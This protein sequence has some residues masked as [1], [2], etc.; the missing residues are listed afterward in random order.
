MQIKYLNRLSIHKL[1]GKTALLRVDLNIKAG[2]I[3]DVYRLSAIIPTLA[4]LK[5]AKVKTI[6]LSHRGRPNG[7]D[8]SLSLKNFAPLLAKKIRAKVAFIPDYNLKTIKEKIAKTK[9]SFI[10]LENLRFFEGEKKNDMVFAKELA[11]LGN[12]YINDAFA[13]SHRAN[14]SVEA[15]TKFLPSY[16]GLLLEKEIKSLHKAMKQYK[17]PLVLIVGGAKIEDKAGILQY[18]LKK[19]DFILLGG[20]VA[21]TFARARGREIKESLFDAKANIE[22]IKNRKNII[23]PEDNVWKND[24]IADIGP[25]ARTRYVKIIK[26]AKTIVWGGPMG[27]FEETGCKEGTRA[28]WRAILKNK[29]AFSVVGGG[30]TTASFSLIKKL[31]VKANPHLFLSTGGGAMLDFLSGQ[32]LPGIEA[33][34]K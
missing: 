13:V 9:E 7:P 16:A 20:G 24:M 14:A 26:K 32:K 31:K 18:F 34:K 11:S 1:K 8:P 25:K 22:K 27:K 3:G 29:R 12:V 4:L 28:V 17:K 30:E 6:I 33:L 10:L 2:D 21:N 5:N 23:I 19:A 15:I